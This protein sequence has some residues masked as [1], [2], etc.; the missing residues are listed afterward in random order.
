MVQLPDYP[1]V[2]YMHLDVV[3]NYPDAGKALTMPYFWDTGIVKDYPPKE[4]LLKTLEAVRRQSEAHGRPMERLVHPD[5]FRHA[6]R[7]SVYRNNDG[8]PELVRT[9]VSLLDFLLKEG[10]LEEDE[11]IYVGGRPDIKCDV[12]HLYRALMEQSRGATNVVTV[13]PGLVI[14]FERNRLT[15]NE[16]RGH[17][18]R[19][20]EWEDSYLD[21]LGGPHCSTSPLSRD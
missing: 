18:V 14:A 7:C 12:E 2:D 5:H 6:G 11:L 9:E 1:A 4:L 8:K 20:K 21:M 3:I 17:G 13:K 19:V 16:L 10:K 15:I